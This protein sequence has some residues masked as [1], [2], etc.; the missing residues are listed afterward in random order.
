MDY[1]GQRLSELFFFWIIMS[2]GGIGWT[3]GYIQQD[4]TIVF[5]SWLVGVLISVIVS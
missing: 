2:F 1:E 3:I 4:F 5:Q